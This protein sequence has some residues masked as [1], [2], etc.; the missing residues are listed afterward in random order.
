MSVSGTINRVTYAGNGSTTVFS[1]PYYLTAFSDLVVLLTD[2]SGNVTTEILNS[3]YTMSG[4]LD[5]N[6]LYSGGAS[7][8]FGTAPPTGYTVT[9]YREVPE[10]QPVVWSDGDADPASAKITA[11][12]RLCLEIQ[13]LRDLA[14]RSITLSDG[15][16]GIFAP[17]IPAAP[18]PGNAPLMSNAGGTGLAFGSPVANTPQGS[19]S[20]P[21]LVSSA[22]ISPNAGL[23][24]Q[25]IY[26]EGSG[27][28]VDLT[29]VNP[30]ITQPAGL[31]NGQRLLLIGCSSINTVKLGNGNGLSRNGTYTKA[32]GSV[33]E[34]I[35]D[36]VSLLWRMICDNEI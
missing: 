7:V 25:T 29:G 34:Y 16:V 15:Y 24:F 27:G 23:L 9:L 26:I 21:T 14:N 6:N 33:S 1:F 17:Q 2:A 36:A 32:L 8:T 13:R 4:T 20:A 5:A 3:N 12:D 11:A 28:A 19:T 18:I 22:G 30:Q 31:V 10:T 35:W